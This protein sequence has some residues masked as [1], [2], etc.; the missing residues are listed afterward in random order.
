MGFYIIKRIALMV[1]TLLGIMLINFIIIQSAP[2]GPVD[3]ALA[4]MS[5]ED[6]AATQGMRGDRKS[7]V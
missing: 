2:G 6:T 3:Q 7:V 5:G 1:P 4:R